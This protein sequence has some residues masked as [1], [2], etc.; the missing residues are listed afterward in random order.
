LSAPI[1]F[2]TP[3]NDPIL[4]GQTKYLPLASSDTD[5]AVNTADS[6]SRSRRYRHRLQ[7]RGSV[8][9][10]GPNARKHFR[11]TH[12]PTDEI[13]GVDSKRVQQ[14]MEPVPSHLRRTITF[15]VVL[16]DNTQSLLH[17]KLLPPHPNK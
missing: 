17:T 5:S 12:L 4:L 14:S 8:C 7:N 15:V 2:K 1:A 3:S 10:I 16:D 9:F 6:I 11:T 13:D